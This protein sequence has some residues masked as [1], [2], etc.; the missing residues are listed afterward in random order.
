LCGDA[1]REDHDAT[2]EV[3]AFADRSPSNKRGVL[4]KRALLGRNAPVDGLAVNRD[5]SGCFSMSGR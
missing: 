4:R 2:E 3:V 5:A 1:R